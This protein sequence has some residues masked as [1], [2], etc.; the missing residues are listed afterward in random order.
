MIVDIRPNS[1]CC[2]EFHGLLTLDYWQ[3]S[4]EFSFWKMKNLESW[5][6]L[7]LNLRFL[8]ESYTSIHGKWEF[9][10]KNQ[11][12]EIELRK[13]SEYIGMYTKF[14]TFVHF[15]YYLILHCG[16]CVNYEDS[17]ERAWRVSLPVIVVVL[18][19]L[20]SRIY[21][22]YR[23]NMTAVLSHGSDFLRFFWIVFDAKVVIM[24]IMEYKIGGWNFCKKYG[25]CKSE[26]V[27]LPLGEIFK[28]SLKI[29]ES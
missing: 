3:S 4:M 28:I 22:L 23:K 8:E 12:M 11:S 26:I 10:L 29:K 9:F 17:M 7:R 16:Q 25:F 14:T 19:S 15:L 20:L 27:Y 6:N 21:S 13:R 18:F 24:Y 5:S 1:L 2:N